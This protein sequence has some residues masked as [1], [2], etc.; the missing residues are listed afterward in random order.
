MGERAACI[1]RGGMGSEWSGM[2]GQQAGSMDGSEQLE[3]PA[4]SSTAPIGAL[5]IQVVLLLNTTHAQT[6]ESHSNKLDVF[7]NR[8][9]C[10]IVALSRSLQT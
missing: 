3:Q 8:L 4:P 2:G 6:E 10:T 1:L 7:H 5:H 9:T